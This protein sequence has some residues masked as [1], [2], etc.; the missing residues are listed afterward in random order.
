MSG[1]DDLRR[2]LETHAGQAPVSDPTVR[3]AAVHERIR[4]VRRR[5]RASALGGVAA[6][7]VLTVGVLSLDGTSTIDSSPPAPA[8]A[9]VFGLDVPSTFESLGF[10]YNFQEVVSGAGSVRLTL[11]PSD[12]PLLVSWATTTADR[13]TVTA[14]GGGEPR[15][16][17]GGDFTDWTVIAPGDG[18]DLVADVDDGS[19]ALAVYTLGDER[20]EGVTADGV[21]FRSTYAGQPLIGAT[22][23]E[24]GQNQ[25]VVE[26]TGRTDKVVYAT[27]CSGGPSSSFVQVDTDAGASTVGLCDGTVPVDAASRGGAPVVVEPDESLTARLS[28][29]GNGSADDNLVEAADVRLGLGVYAAPA[30]RVLDSGVAFAETV[31]HDGHLWRLGE[32]QDLTLG[33]AG[34][35][36]S[37]PRLEGRLLLLLRPFGTGDATLGYTIDDV[38]GP[39][40]AGASQTMTVDV[41][42]GARRVAMVRVGTTPLTNGAAGFAF[43]VRAD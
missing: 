40:T 23:G 11:D 36:L 20:P 5:R 14:S 1:L 2:S 29:R 42:K 3:R 33:G 37:I 8:G 6:A 18:F 43:Y 32:A 26:P 9:T 4:V 41:P 28:V 27:Y 13:L 31:E 22:I 39:Q 15:V 10:D 16:F 25:V 19:A 30:E 24:V 17:D 34:A 35:A 21:T 7:V 38:V 12:R